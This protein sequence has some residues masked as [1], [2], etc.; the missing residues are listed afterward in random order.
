MKRDIYKAENDALDHMC[1]AARR[2]VRLQGGEEQD[3][4]NKWAR[5][6]QDKYLGLSWIVHS[7]RCAC[8]PDRRK[9]PEMLVYPSRVP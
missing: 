5:A 9:L 8:G 2:A 3:R 7:E 1:E 4:A 6:W